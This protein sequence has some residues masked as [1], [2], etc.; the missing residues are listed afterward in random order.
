MLDRLPNP[1]RAGVATAFFVAVP[2][3]LLSLIGWL[4]ELAEWAA[5]DVIEF[6]DLSA[7]RKAA[8]ALVLAVVL[9][10]INAAVRWVQE[11]A[12]G[13]TN[14]VARVIQATG[15]PPVYPTVRR[16]RPLVAD[17]TKD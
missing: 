16:N 11:R 4:E 9:G 10:G 13:S 14:P 12:Q 1:I 3:F 17:R 5:G 15:S 7:L 6:P 2:G 8:V